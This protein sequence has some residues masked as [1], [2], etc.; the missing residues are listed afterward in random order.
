MDRIFPEPNHWL[1]V[2]PAARHLRRGVME[3]L[4][5]M[6]EKIERFT[7]IEKMV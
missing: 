5:N 2:S 3:D 6:E 7:H 4:E 1:Q